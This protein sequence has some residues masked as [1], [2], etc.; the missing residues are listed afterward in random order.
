MSRSP[1]HLAKTH[2]G[3]QAPITSKNPTTFL[4]RCLFRVNRISVPQTPI[5]IRVPET[6]QKN[7]IN[8]PAPTTM[9][10]MS[11]QVSVL[12]PSLQSLVI[13]STKMVASSSSLKFATWKKS[14]KVMAKRQENVAVPLADAAEV[15]AK[16]VVA[17]EDADETNHVTRKRPTRIQAIVLD[18]D[19]ETKKKTLHANR[20]VVVQNLLEAIEVTATTAMTATTEKVGTNEAAEMTATTETNEVTET[21]A[22]AETSAETETREG[23]ATTV[24]NSSSKTTISPTTK[25][26]LK[27][28]AKDDRNDAV[29]AVAVVVEAVATTSRTTTKT[30]AQ[31]MVSSK[32]PHVT[33]TNAQLAPSVG[34]AVIATTNEMIVQEMVKVPGANADHVENEVAGHNATT[35]MI[36][37]TAIGT[38]KA[39][40]N[41]SQFQLGTTRSAT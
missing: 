9:T 23:I 18:A 39:E 24:K 13:L 1:N 4:T 5:P 17:K 35:A 7:R 11:S 26:I 20:E 36:A 27:H 38:A 8:L 31:K 22:V 33:M 2:A 10:M 6:N 21:N 19:E 16:V 3:I 29:E 41:E 14:L 37:T 15:E 25:T 40:R 32:N 30:I 34:A 28:E 12:N